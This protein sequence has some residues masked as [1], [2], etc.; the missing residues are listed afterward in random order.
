MHYLPISNIAD[1]IWSFGFIPGLL[2]AGL[3]LLYRCHALP[4]RRL[5]A[6]LRLAAPARG[7]NAQSG[8]NMTGFQSACT[9]LGSTVGTGNIVGTAQAVTMGGPGA[10]FWLWA[11]AV[12]GMAVKYAEIALAARF[13]PGRGQPPWGPMGY[14]AAGLNS[15]AAARLYALFAA[16]AGL[17][18]GNLTQVSSITDCVLAALPARLL[19]ADTGSA[20]LALGFLLA[21]LTLAVLAGG[22]KRVG[23]VSELLFPCMGLLFLFVC[24]LVAAANLPRLPRVFAAVFRGAF[25]PRSVI[26]AAGGIGL[27]ECVVWGVRRGAFSNEAGL[28]SA[29]L[30]HCSSPAG[31]PARE[32]LWGV[33]EVFAST[34]LICSAAGITVLCSGIPIP[35]GEAVGPE[36]FQR[37]VASVVGEGAAAVL[38]CAV[39]AL[40]AFSTLLGWAH[41]GGI[42]ARYL[43]GASA[44]G[45]Y[46]AIFAAV[47]VVG[48][49]MSTY[50]VWALA[51][52]FN[53]LMSL[54]NLAALIALSPLVGKI[55][56]D[57]SRGVEYT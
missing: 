14:I 3:L 54:P 19:G 49:V 12:L 50:S 21:A 22:A 1:F 24:A 15:C 51:D 41:Y 42:C 47:T 40:F 37:A 33:F 5:G 11:A 20:R 17:G 34:V 55:S 45:V 30:A 44:Q 27:R 28:G 32:G 35:W 2:A 18:M 56:L 36:L 46:T 57:E 4:L 26:G 38:V 10:L 16:L 13:R 7:K 29:A 39:I 48:S 6:A 52:L 31:N 23:R 53:A 43:L 25:S 9:A 8:E